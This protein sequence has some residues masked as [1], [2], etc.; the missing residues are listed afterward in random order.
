MP[1]RRAAAVLLL[2]VAACGEGPAGGGDAGVADGAADLREPVVGPPRYRVEA[3]GGCAGGG[4]QT[5]IAQ[6]AG[7]GAGAHVAFASLAAAG[8]KGT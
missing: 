7:A 8:K 2:V 5:V 4:F 6:G 3:V 1:R